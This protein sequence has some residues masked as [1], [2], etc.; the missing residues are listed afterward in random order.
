MKHILALSSLLVLGVLA[1]TSLAQ[2]TTTTE[3]VINDVTDTVTVD[4]HTARCSIKGYGVPELK[5]SVPGLANIAYFN[6]VNRGE[7]QP[8]ITA[9]ACAQGNEPSDLGQPGPSPEQVPIRVTLVEVRRIDTIAHTCERE[10]EERVSATIRG[11]SF[12][13]LRSAPLGQTTELG[14]D[15]P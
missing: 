8:C 13:H 3:K 6:H 11:K 2:N 1:Q 9:G 10:L 4:L 7:T 14:C 5:V 12:T 15:Q